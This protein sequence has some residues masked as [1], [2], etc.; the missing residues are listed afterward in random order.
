MLQRLV[1]VFC[2][3]SLGSAQAEVMEV[4]VWKTIPGKGAE[5]AAAFKEAR[6]IHERHG[7]GVSIINDF[8][9]NTRYVMF[10]DSWQ[11]WNKSAGGFL[12]DKE[13]Q[14]LIARGQKD[15]VLEHQ[16]NHLINIIERSETL[17]SVVET[18]IWEPLPGGNQRLFDAG[19]RSKKLHEKAGVSVLVGADRL[20]RMIYSISFPDWN[21]YAKFMDTPNPEYQAFMAKEMANPSGKLVEVITGSVQE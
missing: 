10:F 18:Y 6:A 16:A 11:A 21:A 3:L 4:N 9:F 20:D 13:W 1:F 12:Q 2:L 5:A 17:G 19:L 7:A 14:A 8:E 15:P